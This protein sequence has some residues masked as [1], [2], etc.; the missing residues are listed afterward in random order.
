M[1]NS[2][3]TLIFLFV[4]FIVFFGYPWLK[5]RR[6]EECIKSKLTNGI[7]YTGRD[8][9]LIEDAC[10]CRCHASK[11]MYPFTGQI[12]LTKKVDNKLDSC[13]SAVRDHYGLGAVQELERRKGEKLYLK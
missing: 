6:I 9:A 2:S 12:F 1:K 10:N 5:D 13:V 7:E 8:R 11:I 3:G 4:L